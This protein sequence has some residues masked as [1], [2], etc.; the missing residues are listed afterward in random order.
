MS[1]GPADSIADPAT[2]NQ[3]EDTNFDTAVVVHPNA[4][5]NCDGLE[6]DRSEA[7][8]ACSCE[9]DIERSDLQPQ[10]PSSCELDIERSDLQP[11]L[12]S[13]CELDFESDICEPLPPA[14]WDVGS[15][16][17]DCARRTGAFDGND[18]NGEQHLMHHRNSDPLG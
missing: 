16:V 5:P 8:P 14:S 2:I 13:S 1:S 15:S 3:T 4:H 6:R 10:L 12:P 9:L 11:L 7:L 17:L 18:G